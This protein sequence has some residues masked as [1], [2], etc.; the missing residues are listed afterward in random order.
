MN[1]Y[2]IISITVAFSGLILGGCATQPAQDE[3]IT[4]IDQTVTELRNHLQQI[5]VK[6]NAYR[7]DQLDFALLKKN[8]AILITNLDKISQ[9]QQAG[10]IVGEKYDQYL[11]KT[12]S[13]LY[14]IWL[15]ELEGS[16]TNNQFDYV[17]QISNEQSQVAERIDVQD[18][19]GSKNKQTAY[20]NIQ[21]AFRDLNELLNQNN[22]VIANNGKLAQQK[23]QLEDLKQANDI[24][25]YNSLTKEY[26]TLIDKNTELIASYN[27][28]V[29]K[30]DTRYL[31][32]VFLDFIDINQILPQQT[33]LNIQ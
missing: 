11:D 19:V 26:N 23:K 18:W 3:T 25:N 6:D 27:A 4:S 15:E 13:A 5:S 17:L 28:L 10:T 30:Y 7:N 32:Q 20:D 21:T 14:F 29:Q 31:N 33:K 9:K 16:L 12:L 22:A 1:Y 8:K 24:T 2:K